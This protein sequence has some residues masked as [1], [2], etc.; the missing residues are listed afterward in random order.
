MIPRWT[1]LIATLGQRRGKL[2][3]LLAGLMSQVDYALGQVTV[4]ALWN[5]GE[6]PVGYVRQDLLNSAEADYVCFIDD[7]DEVPPYYVDRVLPL[8][9][10]VDYI[11]WR[12]QAYINGHAMAPTY[13]SLRYTTWYQDGLGHYRDISHLNPVRRSLTEGTSFCADPENVVTHEDLSWTTQMRGR[14][15]TEHYIGDVMYYYRYDQN[16]S[17]QH[18]TPIAAGHERL[19]VPSKYFTYLKP[20]PEVFR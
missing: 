11:G 18:G 6:R 9:D 8:L 15:H 2:E 5:N 13:H 7:D 17:I 12:M 4:H 14:L 3:R 16:D 20:P 1:I 10:G 19:E